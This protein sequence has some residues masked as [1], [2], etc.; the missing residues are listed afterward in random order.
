MRRP[1]PT[2]AELVLNLVP[3]VRAVGLSLS[4]DVESGKRRRLNASQ[5]AEKQKEIDS[6]LEVV[7]DTDFVFLAT[8]K[9]LRLMPH[10]IRIPSVLEKL[11]DSIL[12]WY[13]L[14]G[15]RGRF[16]IDL[17]EMARNDKILAGLSGP[18]FDL[19]VDYSR[20]RKALAYVLI[21]SVAGYGRLSDKQ[22]EFLGRVL[23]G[24]EPA[25]LKDSIRPEVITAL[26]LLEIPWKR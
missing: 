9:D 22:K 3:L 25:V 1:V 4:P 6:Y 24:E 15:A 5:L 8:D 2:R 26:R 10:M 20:G 21:N 16:G 11:P 13:V 17:F 19:L 7:R 14:D 23:S 18:F 12:D